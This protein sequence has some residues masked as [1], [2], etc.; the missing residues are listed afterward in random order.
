MLG[1]GVFQVFFVLQKINQNIKLNKNLG[2][3]PQPPPPPQPPP[4]PPSHNYSKTFN[5]QNYE[6]LK[7]RVTYELLFQLN[8][9]KSP[10]TRIPFATVVAVSPSLC[11]PSE[12]KQRESNKLTWRNLFSP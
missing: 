7:L 9:T 1:H 2:L 12:T 6:L 4:V 5:L 10:S 8:D 3:Q 11:Q